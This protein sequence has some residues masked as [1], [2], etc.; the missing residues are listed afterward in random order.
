MLISLKPGQRAEVNSDNSEATINIFDG[1]KQVL[2]ISVEP[3]KQIIAISCIEGNR[4]GNALNVQ[5]ACIASIQAR[6]S[7]LGYIGTEST[8]GRE[9]TE[10]AIE[11][12]RSVIAQLEGTLF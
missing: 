11:E 4:N 7:R 9:Q 2:A 8:D 3:N 10:K 6:L 12:I 1:P 5:K